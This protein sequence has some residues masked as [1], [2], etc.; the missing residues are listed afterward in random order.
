MLLFSPLSWTDNSFFS[1]SLHLSHSLPKIRSVQVVWV[2]ISD[3][4]KSSADLD[5]SLFFFSLFF[6]SAPLSKQIFAPDR[7]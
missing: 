1:P 3:Q 7:I 4:I 5:Y 2:S 6:L